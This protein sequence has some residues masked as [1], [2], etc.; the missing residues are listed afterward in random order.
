MLLPM[1]MMLLPMMLLPM[2][3]MLLP[4]MMLDYDASN[5]KVYLPFA[6]YHIYDFL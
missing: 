3:M 2:M 1:M 4:M 5:K 6:H